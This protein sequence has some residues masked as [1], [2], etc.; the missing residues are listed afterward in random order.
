M[1]N[2]SS[3]EGR[4]ATTSEQRAIHRRDS[5]FTLIELMVVL[6][7]IAILL[8]VAIPT[9]LGVSGSANDRSAQS[10]LSNAITEIKALYQNTQTYNSGSVPVAT[11]NASA[12]EFTWNQASACAASNGTSC[13][14]E[15]PVDVASGADGA[16][17][18][19]ADLSKTG[20]CW[21]LVDLYAAPTTAVLFNGGS[22]D[23]GT[24]FTKQ[25]LSSTTGANAQETS[26][27]AALTHAGLYY[28]QVAKATTCDARIPTTGGPWKWGTSYATAAAN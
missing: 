8:A 1:A 28:A 17:V 27:G 25:F 21:Y 23:S 11:L 4:L 2:K 22:V 3:I 24:G 26:A 13:V 10:N 9:F 19:L 18:I 14:S 15:Y 6:L 5:G 20:T 12:P 7:I 16:G